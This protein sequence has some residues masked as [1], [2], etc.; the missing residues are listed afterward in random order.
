MKDNKNNSD[1]KDID[2]R[3]FDSK[4]FGSEDLD[5]LVVLGES[6][7]I[8]PE[9]EKPIPFD[10]T[11]QSNISHAPL[12]LDSSTTSLFETGRE[13]VTGEKSAPE[14][15]TRVR[16][17]FTKLHAG[18]IDFLDQQINNWLR[19]NPG[20]VI[21][22]TNTTVGSVVAKKTEPNIVITIWY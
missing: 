21:K 16:T 10:D 4:D 5:E 20:I 6:R 14:R 1:S 8:S 11:D 12:N 22:G 17:F 13:K 19:D 15:I 7:T 9:E 18:S 3:D 2:T